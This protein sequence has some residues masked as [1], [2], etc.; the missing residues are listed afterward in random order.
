MLGLV[1]AVVSPYC[2]RKSVSSSPPK[3][4]GTTSWLLGE[5]V[6]GTGGYFLE[7]SFWP[8]RGDSVLVSSHLFLLDGS[9]CW[10]SGGSFAGFSARCAHEGSA[11]LCLRALSPSRHLPF[12]S[13]LLPKEVGAIW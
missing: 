4:E 13:S 5:L 9:S 10:L 7:V 12:G 1:S 6:E 11:R 2:F 3:G 8:G